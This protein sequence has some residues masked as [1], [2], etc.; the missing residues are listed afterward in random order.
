VASL[1]VYEMFERCIL[2]IQSLISR[3]RR[4]SRDVC[5]KACA[6]TFIYPRRVSVLCD[7]FEKKK[8]IV[9]RRENIFEATRRLI[10]RNVRKL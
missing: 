4:D 7:F 3:A 6:R 8:E 9:R 10:F 5:G 2:Q 1:H